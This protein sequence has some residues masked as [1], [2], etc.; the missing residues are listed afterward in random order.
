M[1]CTFHKDSETLLR[2]SKCELPI[3]DRCAVQTP[4]GA[5]CPECANVQRIPTYNLSTRQLVQ[6]IGVSMVVGLVLGLVLGL[7]EN[8]I[9][10]RMTWIYVPASFVSS[11][12]VIGASISRVTN[13]KR[14]PV[15]Q[16]LA[17]GGYAVAFMMYAMVA[18][19]DLVIGFYT[20][21]GLALGG[22]L[23]LNPFR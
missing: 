19:Q 5:R 18:P 16:G 15:L 7:C 23:A 12:Y 9:P 14:A 2:C 3:C 8:L 13:H 11:G 20:L 4:V 22:A 17:I 10:F 6:A 1:Q 21:A